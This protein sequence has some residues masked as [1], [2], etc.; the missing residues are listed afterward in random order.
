MK[1]KKEI[2]K[3]LDE[4]YKCSKILVERTFLHGVIFSMYK[5]I[6]DEPTILFN[7]DEL[8]SKKIIKHRL[9]QIIK[10]VNK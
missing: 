10:K 8:F 3:E 2:I 6:V 7:K 9:E 4:N 5:A 1:D